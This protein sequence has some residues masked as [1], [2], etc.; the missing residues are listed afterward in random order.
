MLIVK[1][2]I[3]REIDE[4]DLQV[5]RDKGYSVAGEKDSDEKPEKKKSSKEKEE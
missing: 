5:Y 2:G 1:G 4:K 3:S